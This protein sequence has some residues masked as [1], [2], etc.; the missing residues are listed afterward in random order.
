M[1]RIIRSFSSF[2]YNDK[3]LYSKTIGEINKATTILPEV[4]R[5]KDFFNEEKDKIFKKS[6]IP[7]GYTNQFNDKTNII[8]SNIHKIPLILT[9]SK[10]GNIQGYYNVC[11][12]RGCKLINTEKQGR[13]ITCPYHYWSY[14]LD[15]TL[16]NTPNFKPSSKDFHK[17][18]YSLFPVNIE[19]C[20]NIIFGNLD[21][22]NPSSIKEDF[23]NF[24]NLL[25]NYPLKDC[26]IVKTKKYF[27]DCN[28]KLLIDNFI[29]Y[30]HLP[31]V[32]K[33][34]VKVST[35]QGHE[36]TQ[37]DGLYIS[38]KTD[39]LSE[40]D[41]PIDPKKSPPFK[42][43]PI[44]NQNLAHFGML[45]PNMFIF[46]FPNHMFSVIIEPVNETESI[47][48][49]VLITE[50]DADKKWIDNLWKFYDK[51]NKEDIKICEDV[52][53]GIECDIYQGG[54][55]VPEFESTIHRFHKMIIGKMTT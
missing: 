41:F 37:E 24:F 38:F 47:E 26:S 18:K 4:Y 21:E 34:L 7:L 11:R 17:S 40:S 5:K 35:L 32:H 12:H 45:F 33:E 22:N 29:E 43:L 14:G 2:K 31:A 9:K 1:N 39:P 48:H 44:E 42:N 54:R 46:L 49:A 27:I 30:Y 23:G 8:P 15:G 50:N 16:L 3:N 53:K 19:I 55:M 52:Q 13:S 36:C 20:N 6:W 51:V 28:W 10:S 25:Q